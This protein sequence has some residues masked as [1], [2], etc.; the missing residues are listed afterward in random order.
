MLLKH[1]NVNQNLDLLFL[2]KMK[3]VTLFVS[4]VK[5]YTTQQAGGVRKIPQL[6]SVLIPIFF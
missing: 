6:S 1:G 3:N 2:K 5:Q 4:H